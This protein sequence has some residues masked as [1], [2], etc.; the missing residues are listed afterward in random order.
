MM[1]RDAER[2]QTCKVESCTA[3][4]Y[5]FSPEVYYEFKMQCGGS[6]DWNDEEPPTHCPNCGAKVVSE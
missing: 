2:R 6:F 3:F 5:D 1:K 4:S